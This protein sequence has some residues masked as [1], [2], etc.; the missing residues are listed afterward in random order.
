[1]PSNQLHQVVRSAG[2]WTHGS[3]SSQLWPWYAH[4]QAW[5][6]AYPP[7][8][9]PRELKDASAS[10]ASC[11]YQ[12]KSTCN[13]PTMRD[14]RTVTLC[15]LP[16][17]ARPERSACDSE[18]TMKISNQFIADLF[19]FYRPLPMPTFKMTSVSSLAHC[20]TVTSTGQVDAQV[21]I[22]P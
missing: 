13:D 15:K 14:Q 1:M 2:P 11:C 19:P 16:R 9:M 6:I 7:R 21:E 10:V 20:Q 4:Q 3:Q 17:Q 5:T 8:T 12:S 18:S 22:Q